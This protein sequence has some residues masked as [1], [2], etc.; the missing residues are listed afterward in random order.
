MYKIQRESEVWC[1]WHIGSC[2][3]VVGVRALSMIT[4]M[5]KLVELSAKPPAKD[6]LHNCW[7]FFFIWFSLL[8]MQCTQ[9]IQ[10]LF[11]LYV[12]RAFRY[13]CDTISVVSLLQPTV[14]LCWCGFG[15]W[16]ES[17]CLKCVKSLLHYVLIHNEMNR[18]H[19]KLYFT[20]S[21]NTS[22]P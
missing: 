8:C 11:V 1:E 5:F 19:F 13:N 17:E 2:H 20:K 15:Y 12:M 4:I 16:W 6:T 10:M 7:N 22:E 18:N 9:Y 21:A 14:L 3:L